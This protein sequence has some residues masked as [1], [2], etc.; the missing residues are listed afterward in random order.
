V[1]EIKKVH[2]SGGNGFLGKHILKSLR[3]SYSLLLSD[4]DDC[5]VLDLDSLIKNFSKKKPDLVI[6]LA[7]I[8][9]GH[10]SKK[11]LYKTFNI[12]SFGLMN[13]LEACKI[14]GIKNII[15]FSSLTVHGNSKIEGKKIQETDQYQTNH[16]YATSKIISEYILK[17]YQKY[18]NINTIVLRPTIIVGNLEGE[19]NALNEFVEE[20]YLDK[21]IT[22]YGSGSHEREYLS[23]FDLSQAVKAS[24]NYLQDKDSIYE[25]FIISSNESISMSNLAK[26]AINKIG[27]GKLNFIKKNSRAFSL[28]S[29]SLKA[30]KILKWKPEHSKL[31]GFKKGLEKTIKW[32][33]DPKNLK[34]YNPDVYSI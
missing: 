8:M 32:F 31:S 17:D 26:L 23:V 9:G 5:N 6:A 34:F 16:P 27:K 14:T 1:N 15:F 13:V 10:G 33:K 12:N 11:D 25:D 3:N 22:I 18:Y 29:D 24:I 20:L 4:I 2:I 19:S 7:G 21:D 28:V 30:K